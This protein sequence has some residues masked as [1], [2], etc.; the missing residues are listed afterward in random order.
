MGITIYY[1]SNL[2]LSLFNFI[3]IILYDIAFFVLMWH[4]FNELEIDNKRRAN[5][6]RILMVLI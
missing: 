2:I 1:T 4:R 5:V 3:S 6:K